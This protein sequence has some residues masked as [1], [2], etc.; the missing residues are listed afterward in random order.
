M[1]SVTTK[2]FFRSPG[3][4]NSLPPGAQ[5]EVTLHGAT[6][7]VAVK[8]GQPRRKTVAEIEHENDRILGA[9]RA[10]TNVRALLS[11]LRA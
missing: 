11:K 10:P 5:M 9:K 1:K 6:S 8:P 3:L 2:T 7:F 4:V